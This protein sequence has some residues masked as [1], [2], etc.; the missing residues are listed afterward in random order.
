MA[1]MYEESRFDPEA[2]SWAGARGLL[3][4]MPRTAAELGLVDLSDPETGILAGIQYL[5]LLRDRFDTD[6]YAED[7]LWFALAGYNAGPGHV[8]DAIRLAREQG[9]NSHR[10]F[11][12]VENAMLLLGRPGHADRA[13][14]GYLD[15][16]GPVGYVRRISRRY[17]E[18]VQLTRQWERPAAIGE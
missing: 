1:V 7:R 16:R 5:A 12:H 13:L 14:H 10:W 4:V 17:G 6:L 9:W 15:G 18:Y 11:G 2:V 8:R 3:Q